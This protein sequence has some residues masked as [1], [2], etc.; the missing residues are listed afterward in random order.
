MYLCAKQN[1]N[2]FEFSFVLSGGGGI[3]LVITDP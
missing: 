2:K 1:L 3:G